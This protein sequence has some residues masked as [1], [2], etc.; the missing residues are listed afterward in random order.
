[1][2]GS[3]DEKFRLLEEMKIEQESFQRKATECQRKCMKSNME[4]KKCLK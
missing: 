4:S 2:V 3:F 1:M